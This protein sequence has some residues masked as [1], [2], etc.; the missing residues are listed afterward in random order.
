MGNVEPFEL[1]ET[2][3]QVQCKECFHYWNQGIVHCTCGH[4]FEG[5]ETSRGIPQWTL[6]LLSQ[7]K[8]VSLGRILHGYRFGKT[9]E[10][11]GHHVAH[12]LRKTASRGMLKRFT[13]V[14]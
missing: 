4:L 9:E 12:N 3:R 1:C 5:S 8:L 6:D 7:L 11:K 13:I 14:S 10:Q 2:N